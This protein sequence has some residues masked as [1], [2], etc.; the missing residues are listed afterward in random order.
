MQKP[1]SQRFQLTYKRRE[2]P[3][4]VPMEYKLMDALGLTRCD[5][6]RLALKELHNR[7]EKS[8]VDLIPV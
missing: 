7:L 2:A 3:V 5:L 8:K 6:H 1:L 4:Y